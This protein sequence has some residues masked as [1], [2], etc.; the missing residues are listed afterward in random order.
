MYS[1]KKK[2]VFLDIMVYGVINVRRLKFLHAI[3]KK[4]KEDLKIYWPHQP[5]KSDNEI[6][7]VLFLSTKWNFGLNYLLLSGNVG[8][9]WVPSLLTKGEH[10]E[11]GRLWKSQPCEP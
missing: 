1:K 7:I 10:D 6:W 2:R 5:T 8:W 9:H 3:L 11:S 4:L